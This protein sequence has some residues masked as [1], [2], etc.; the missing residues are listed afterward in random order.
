MLSL[1]KIPPDPLEVFCRLVREAL[2]SWDL[3]SFELELIGHHPNYQK[4]FVLLVGRGLQTGR[5]V[6]LAKSLTPA[7][8]EASPYRSY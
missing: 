7:C 8:P 4:V 3:S 6:S 5:S 2:K 1:R